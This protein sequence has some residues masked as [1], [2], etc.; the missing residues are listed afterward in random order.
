MV[1]AFETDEVAYFNNCYAF[2]LPEL[3]AHALLVDETMILRNRVIPKL[4]CLSLH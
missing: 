4:I 2:G 3:S 1:Q